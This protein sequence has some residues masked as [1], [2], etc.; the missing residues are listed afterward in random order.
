MNK[1]KRFVGQPAIADLLRMPEL[2]TAF[3]LV[4]ELTMTE[5][6]REIKKQA[7][8]INAIVELK[9]LYAIDTKLLDTQLMLQITVKKSG[10]PPNKRGRKPIKK[11][12][13]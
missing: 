12:L 2:S 5:A 10:N 4:P 7:C 6:Q 1:S 8:G 13:P 9:Q 11:D 3:Y